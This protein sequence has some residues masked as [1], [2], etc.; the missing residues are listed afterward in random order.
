MQLVAGSR[1]GEEKIARLLRKG[2]AYHED[3]EFERAREAYSEV[4]KLDKGNRA[5]RT[6]IAHAYLAEKALK[7][8]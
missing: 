5:A 3:G 4:L 1:A 8:R 6:G 7:E 2:R